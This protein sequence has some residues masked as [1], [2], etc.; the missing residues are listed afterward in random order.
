MKKNINGKNKSS[1]F[2]IECLLSKELYDYF[3]KVVYNFQCYKS[4]KKYYESLINAIKHNYGCED[5][6]ECREIAKELLDGFTMKL[7]FF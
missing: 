4:E 5:M 2:F 7:L 3:K 6:V 1:K